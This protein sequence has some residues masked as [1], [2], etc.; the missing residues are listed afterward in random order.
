LVL[1]HTVSGADISTLVQASVIS[2]TKIT[3][4]AD[5]PGT[6]S[7]VVFDI[8]GTAAKK[9]IDTRPFAFVTILNQL[10]IT[11]ATQILALAVAN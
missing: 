9:R 6:V 3:V 11:V 2:R 7:Y 4:R 10:T 1:V 5:V 8:D